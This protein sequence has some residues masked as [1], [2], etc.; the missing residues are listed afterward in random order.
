MALTFDRIGTRSYQQPMGMI[1]DTNVVRP[2]VDPDCIMVGWVL[3][4]P[5]QR[6]AVWTLKQKVAWVETLLRGLGIPSIIVNQFP[7]EHPVYGFREVVIDGQQRLRATADFMLDKFRVHGE[8]WSEQTQYFQRNFIMTQSVCSVVYCR[9]ETDAECAELY[10]KLLQSGTMHTPLEIK[11]AQ[12][13]LK[14]IE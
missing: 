3:D 7:R 11:K 12:D 9:F 13:Y 1:A 6:G 2:S 10:L 8:L 14:E 4:P 5:F